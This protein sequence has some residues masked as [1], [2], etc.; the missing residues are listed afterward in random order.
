MPESTG[1]PPPPSPVSPA[2]YAEAAAQAFARC[3]SGEEAAEG[4]LA[5]KE[6]RP[7]RWAVAALA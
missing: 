5:F 4:I 6:K 2:D 3:A 1:A 7:P